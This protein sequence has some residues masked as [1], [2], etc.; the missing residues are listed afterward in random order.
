MGI[1]DTA[2]LRPQVFA[3]GDGEVQVGL[4]CS[5]KQAIDA[6]LASLANEDPRFCPVADLYWNARGGSHTTAAPSS[7]TC[8]KSR[9]QDPHTCPDKFGKPVPLPG[10]AEPCDFSRELLSPSESED[11][12]GASVAQA[13]SRLAAG[14]PDDRSAPSQ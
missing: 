8:K 3:F 12:V 9:R 6:T 4:I 1:T 11:P 7:S 2:M 10:G 13:A 14:Q 5:E